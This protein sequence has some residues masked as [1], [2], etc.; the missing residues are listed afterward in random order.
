MIRIEPSALQ[1]LD[2]EQPELCPLCGEHQTTLRKFHQPLCVVVRELE[3]RV[4]RLERKD[5][6]K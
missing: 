2:I 3:E 5:C 4:A 6:A 1:T